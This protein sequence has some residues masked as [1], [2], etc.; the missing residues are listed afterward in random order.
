V[1]LSRLRCKQQSIERD[2][3]KGQMYHR[4]IRFKTYALTTYSTIAVM[5][6]L[7]RYAERGNCT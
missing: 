2:T 5:I 4:A 7:V 1:R 3:L 6:G